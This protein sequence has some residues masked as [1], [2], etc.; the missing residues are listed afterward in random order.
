MAR[1]AAE[2]R[3]AITAIELRLDTATSKVIVDGTTTET[4]LAVLERRLIQLRRELEAVDPTT[5]AR[6][7]AV[8]RVDLGGF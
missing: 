6:K 2:I 7:P 3:E 5:K 4:D 1:T 8:L